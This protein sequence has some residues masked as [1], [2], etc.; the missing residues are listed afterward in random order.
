MNRENEIKRQIENL[1]EEYWKKGFSVVVVE[2]PLLLEAGWKSM[3]DEVWVT[4]APQ[5]TV[6]S[7]LKE[8]KGITEAESL[9][10]IHAQITDAERTEYAD[11]VISTDRTLDELREEIETLLRELNSRI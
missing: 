3:V 8:Q 4:S 9:A 7:R 5:E 10:R 11:V 1:I 2:V 6:I